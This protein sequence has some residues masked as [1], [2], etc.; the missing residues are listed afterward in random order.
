MEPIAN[1]NSDSTGIIRRV[2]IKAVEKIVG[3]KLYGEAAN[4]LQTA[5][6]LNV[7]SP[8][9]DSAIT[10]DRMEFTITSSKITTVVASSTSGGITTTDTFTITYDIDGNITLIV[11]T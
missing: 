11:R 6:I 2:I 8:M 1:N 5:A 3:V 7:V 10:Y 4:Q 9:F